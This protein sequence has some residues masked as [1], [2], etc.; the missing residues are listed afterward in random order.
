VPPRLGVPSGVAGRPADQQVQ[1]GQGGLQL[2]THGLAVPAAQQAPRPADVAAGG[3]QRGAAAVPVV[4]L[5]QLRDDR[6]DLRHIRGPDPSRDRGGTGNA[7][8]QPAVQA[9]GAAAGGDQGHGGEKVAS[10]H[11]VVSFLFGTAEAGAGA[12][13]GH[14][15]GQAQPAARDAEALG[16]P[17]EHLVAGHL[18]AVQDGRD[19]RLRLPAP[20]ADLALAPAA[21]LQPAVQAA[22]VVA[23]QDRYQLGQRP[24]GG[25]RDRR[26][27]RDHVH[28]TQR[29]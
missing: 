5:R 24:P 15:V 1:L 26:R 6:P 25:I 10:F 8:R 14:A 28:A 21:Q 3:V 23:G 16:D 27:C 20:L 22:D 18:A 2:M 7:C 19:L 4:Q 9:D 12:V 17:V 13:A 11:R 29:R